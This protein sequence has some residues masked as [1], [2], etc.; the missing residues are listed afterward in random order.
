MNTCMLGLARV[1]L[2]AGILSAAIVARAGAP[3]G[4]YTIANGTVYDTKTKLTWQQAASPSQYTWSAA[5]SYCPNTFGAGWRVPT[6]RE[7]FT[8]VDTNATADPVIDTT[9]F[10]NTPAS[11]FWS[12]S[13]VAGTTGSVWFVRFTHFGG[14]GSVPTSSGDMFYVRCVR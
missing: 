7:L 12:S 6:Y 11:L 14:T 1:G 4:R 2:C 10:P 5:I 13:T 9:A 8:I 3:G